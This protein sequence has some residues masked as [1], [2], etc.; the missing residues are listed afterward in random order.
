MALQAA[1]RVRKLPPYLFADLRRKMAAA[2]ERGVEVIRIDIGDPDR[3]TPDEI[4]EQLRRAVADTADPDRHRYGC[5][6]PVA[7]LAEAA[8]DF[9]RRRY[10]VKLAQDQV[11]CTMGSKDAI[12]KLCLGILN[13]GDV[14]IAPAP[15]YP[16]Y[17]IGHVFASGVTYQV[18][19]HAENDFLVDFDGD[20]SNFFGQEKLR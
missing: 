5:D 13:P 8:R 12:V 20:F 7:E 4:V 6:R 1:E 18:P 11:V 15:G 16:T 3:P 10:G 14:G 17:N 9:Y 19:L 2:R